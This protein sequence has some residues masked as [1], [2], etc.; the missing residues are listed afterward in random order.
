MSKP[1][2]SPG[3][4]TSISA[5]SVSASAALNV[6]SPI[7]RI[8]NAGTVRAFVRFGVGAQ[9]AVITDMPIAPGTIELFSDGVADTIA[10]ICATGETA[11]IYIT[12]G[13]GS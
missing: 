11:I 1:A 5:T 9:T 8:Y 7:V 12:S 2:F 6:N 3:I 4:T 13:D 10:V